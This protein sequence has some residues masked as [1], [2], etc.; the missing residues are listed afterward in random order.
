M[1]EYIVM[2]RYMKRKGRDAKRCIKPLY[3]DRGLGYRI[4]KV[5][6]TDISC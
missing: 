3:V 4:V 6:N 1:T 5:D 2:R